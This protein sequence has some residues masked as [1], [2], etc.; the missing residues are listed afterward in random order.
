MPNIQKIID[1]LSDAFSILDFSYIISGGF[2]FA[3]ILYDLHYHGYD[4]FILNIPITVICGIFLAYIC[5]LFS[6]IIGKNIRRKCLKNIDS[7]FEQ[8]FDKTIQSINKASLSLPIY[9]SNRKEAYS[10]MWIALKKE[11]KAKEQV[12]FLNRMW[13]MQAVFEGLIFSLI[14]TIPVSIDLIFL[15][16]C[17][18]LNFILAFIFIVLLL[19]SIFLSCIEA[20]RYAREQIK[21]MILSYYYYCCQAKS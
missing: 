9:E 20:Q 8:T 1:V 13:V 12:T 4:F 18:V 14:I 21:G 15:R 7:D 10:Y 16:K 17:I 5:G 6:W 3:A 2:T 19:C 11:E